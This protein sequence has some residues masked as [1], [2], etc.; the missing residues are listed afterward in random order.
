MKI[1][2]KLSFTL[3]GLSII[4]MGM[5]LATFYTT[6]SQ[7]SDGL[8]I[9]L[10]GR[11]RMLSQKMTKEILL[12]SMNKG[13]P[14]ALEISLGIQNTMKVFDMTLAA[15]KDSGKAPLSLNLEK[16]QYS[17]LL[18]AQGPVSSQLKKVADIWAG[19]SKNMNLVMKGESR[20]EDAMKWIINNNILLLKEMN[21]AVVMMQKQSEQKVSVLL[22]NQIIG[23]FIFIP[24]AILTVFICFNVAGAI[25]KLGFML[26]DIAE[27]EGDLTKRI[28]VGA[29]DEIGITAQW[30]NTFIEK[31]QT[32]IVAVTKKTGRLNSSSDEFLK[33][34]EQ[35]SL[36][37]EK[38]SEKSTRVADAVEKMSV[39]MTAIAAAMEQAST[40][41][42]IVASASEEMT[43]A[44]NEI[45]QN[46]EKARQV[47][48]VAVD[49]ASGASREIEELGQ[50]ARE[51]GTVTQTISEISDQTNL[52]ALNA[53]IE[54]AR[55][56]EAGKG[57]A[58]V[59]N[60]IKELAGQT[61]KATHE[62]KSRIENIQV[63]TESTTKKVAQV[64]KIIMDIND[65]VSTISTAV[66]EQSATSNEI[67][68][69][70][71]Q[72]SAGIQEVN[73]NLIQGSEMIRD[74]A[75]DIAG[76]D[77]AA[78]KMKLNSVQVNSN[79]KELSSLARD[80]NTM[81]SR[82]KA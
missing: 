39:S 47:T 64:S 28:K 70:I 38:T 65:I 22:R 71:S 19:F 59:A 6:T 1:I 56:G 57:F 72:A 25:K 37:A 74:I 32:M 15:L 12:F 20:S 34:A 41:T 36:G 76:V 33:I 80:L 26:R 62:I 53:T 75:G 30:F 61:A 11:Q 3:A 79:A 8:G 18:K 16:T 24:I 73:E 35:M 7:K 55:A 52:L 69:N 4:V 42:D 81:V 31:I 44:I 54:A 66:E 48:D 5:F 13:N 43:G 68:S 40:N 82:F 67:S 45:A 21:A 14:R 17:D 29:R 49:Q 2:H 27:G 58:V 50:A 10:A 46:S 60:E 23:I 78:G 51:I 9:N 63:S 77:Q